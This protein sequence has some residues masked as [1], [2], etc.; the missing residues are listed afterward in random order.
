MNTNGRT[1]TQRAFVEGMR[2]LFPGQTQ[3]IHVRMLYEAEVKKFLKKTE[4]SHRRAAHSKLRVGHC[5]S[6]PTSYACQ[7]DF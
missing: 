1:D 2:K 3:I 5:L 7:V 6:F 4:D